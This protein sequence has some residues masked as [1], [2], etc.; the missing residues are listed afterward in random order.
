MVEAENFFRRKNKLKN[1]LNSIMWSMNNF[2][3]YNKTY[4]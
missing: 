4:E 3:K 1:K 2:K